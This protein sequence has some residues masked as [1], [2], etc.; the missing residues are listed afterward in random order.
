MD[1]HTRR[2]KFNIGLAYLEEVVADVLLAAQEDGKEGLE[3]VQVLARVGQKA[4]V[5]GERHGIVARVLTS[6][7]EDGI[8]FNARPGPGGSSWRL[9]RQTDSQ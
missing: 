9:A 2:K 6:L 1:V 7:E 4:D 8:A 5:S 3:V